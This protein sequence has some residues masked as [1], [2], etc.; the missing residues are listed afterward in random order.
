MNDRVDTYSVRPFPRIR[1]AYID[2]L[3]QGR[4]RHLIHGLVEAD[5]TAARRVMR[6]RASERRP[7]SF[8]GFVVACVATAVAEQPM[9]HAYR[10]GRR[11]LVLFDDVD[12]N[13]EVEETRPDGTR[14]V[15][16]RIIRGANRK[17][18]GEIS[19]EIRILFDARCG[20][21]NTCASLSNATTPSFASILTGLHAH[22]HGVL[23]LD[24]ALRV[25]ELAGWHSEVYASDLRTHEPALRE[26]P[27]LVVD[28]LG[29]NPEGLAA[30]VRL[31]AVGKATP[32]GDGA[33]RELLASGRVPTSMERGTVNPTAR[34]RPDLLRA[35]F[36]MLEQVLAGKADRVL[37][38]VDG[39]SLIDLGSGSAVPSVGNAA[40]RVVAAVAEQAARFTHTCFMITPYEGYVAVCERLNELTP[41]SFAKRSMLVNS[42][43]EAVENAVKIARAYTGRQA[44][45]V[46]DH[47]Y[48]GRTNLT[49][50]MTAKNMPYK[51]RFGPFAGELYRVPM[52]YPYRWPGGAEHCAE[53]ALRTVTD[54]IET[55]ARTAAEEGVRAIVFSSTCAV[56]GDP[57]EVPILQ[58]HPRAPVKPSIT[59]DAPPADAPCTA[60]VPVAALRDFHRAELGG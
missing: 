53:E 31:G 59:R 46:F 38:D 41:G 45:V 50:A 35:R 20:R 58:S 37:V 11:R 27:R 5:V 10:S 9:L 1:Q 60:D 43:A 2:V 47:A 34:K 7:L 6:A 39:N 22:R 42:G 18:V 4:R 49:M 3:E 24:T 44:V 55:L 17:T 12:V 48:H 19:A 52:A 51:H 56:Y 54:Q 23:D 8:T 33:C 32:R 36:L 21:M 14:I 30:A 26:L 57:V 13:T 28:H 40:P 15:A 25:H 16:S 29:M